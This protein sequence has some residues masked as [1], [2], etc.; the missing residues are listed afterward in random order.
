MPLKPQL[1]KPNVT[2]TRNPKSIRW[3]GENKSNSKKS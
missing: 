2:I 3:N 1:S